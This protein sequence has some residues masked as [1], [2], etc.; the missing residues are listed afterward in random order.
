MTVAVSL[1]L[2][3]NTYTTAAAATV[4]AAAAFPADDAL[5]RLDNDNDAFPA[6]MVYPLVLSPFVV[7]SRSPYIRFAIFRRNSVTDYAAATDTADKVLPSSLV[8]D[9][10]NAAYSFI[11]ANPFDDYVPRWLIIVCVCLPAPPPLSPPFHPLSIYFLQDYT[12]CRILRTAAR[13]D[14]DYY[15]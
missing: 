7:S 8:S 12:V 9:R 1:L 14:E 10:V 13:R 6:M 4:T 2:P 11:S 5:G 3:L 15:F